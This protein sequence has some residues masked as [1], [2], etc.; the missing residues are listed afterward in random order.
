MQALGRNSQGTEPSFRSSGASSTR[1]SQLGSSDLDLFVG[2]AADSY[3][4]ASLAAARSSLSIA[5]TFFLASPNSM[6]VFSRK[7]SGF[8]T[9]A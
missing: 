1:F 9:P 8:S 7:N 5:S 3:S 4:A 6:N 2:I